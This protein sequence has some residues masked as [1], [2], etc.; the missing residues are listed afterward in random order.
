MGDAGACPFCGVD[1][2]VVLCCDEAV[3]VY[4][5]HP[6]TP[7]HMLVIPRR[8]MVSIFEADAGELAGVM[9]LVARVR[10]HL[11]A[12]HAPDG[13]NVG[14]NDGVAAG[15]TVMH[16]HIH[17]IPRYLS[18]SADPRG[19]VRWIMPERAPYWKRLRDAEAE[20]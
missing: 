10:E 20:E 5:S 2:G 9:Q 8:H 12:V 17:V 14:I 13:F 16:A 4:D 11:S 3:A 7:G 15:Q 6:V 18:D 1:E 19:G